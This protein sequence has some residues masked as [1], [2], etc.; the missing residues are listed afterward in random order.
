MH[1]EEISFQANIKFAYK[2]DLRMSSE[3]NKKINSL[4]ENLFIK[5]KG[6]VKEKMQEIK[7]KNE[8]EIKKEGQ[9]KK[10]MLILTLKDTSYWE[11]AS[12]DYEY[13]LGEEYPSMYSKWDNFKSICEEYSSSKGVEFRNLV[14]KSGLEFDYKT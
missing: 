7:Q 5:Q 4:S 11:Y 10:D 2:E 3:F 9:I 8:G 6:L 12:F 1:T 14:L 13:L